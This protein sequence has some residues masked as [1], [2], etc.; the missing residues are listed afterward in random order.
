MLYPTGFY[1]RAD[2]VKMRRKTKVISQAQKM[3]ETEMERAVE[4][5]KEHLKEV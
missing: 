2:E 3:K 4:I 1:N 5:M